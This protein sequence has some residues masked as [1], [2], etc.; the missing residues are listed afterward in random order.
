MLGRGGRC[1]NAES[2]GGLGCCT[3]NHCTPGSLTG[4]SGPPERRA[5]P[6]SLLGG[7]CVTFSTCP[8]SPPALTVADGYTK[9]RTR[10]LTHGA[11][12]GG[13]RVGDSWQPRP[14]SCGSPASAACFWVTGPLGGSGG[15][16]ASV[17]RCAAGVGCSGGPCGR[18]REAGEEWPGVRGAAR[19]P[20]LAPVG[21]DEPP[22]WA[23]AVPV[24]VGV[25]R[26]TEVLAGELRPGALVCFRCRQGAKQ[27]QTRAFP[28]SASPCFHLDNFTHGAGFH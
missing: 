3:R 5:W 17:R 22:P 8:P 25:P 20:S 11:G 12:P 15:R 23:G 26:G 13:P 24:A 1:G 21:K 4:G 2:S 10:R 9:G 16:T 27:R 14:A 18:H 7:A 28:G 19:T 6:G